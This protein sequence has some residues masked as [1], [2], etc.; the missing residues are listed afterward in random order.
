M[1]IAQT[2]I[3]N[4]PQETQTIG[5]TLAASLMQRKKK[6]ETLPSICLYGELG[7]G[8]TVITQGIGKGLGLPFRLVSP[9]FIIS[10]Q[11]KGNEIIPYINHVDLYRI[12]GEQSLQSLGI[13]EMINDTDAVTIIEWADRLGTMLPKKRIDVAITATGD[14]KRNILITYDQ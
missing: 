6:G 5:Q 12:E 8:K 13:E 9:T 11:Y 3:T 2:I 14:T 1:G 10:K 4:S 7:A